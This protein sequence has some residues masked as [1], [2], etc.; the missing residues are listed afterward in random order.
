[1]AL[2][3][4]L[5]VTD[6]TR[7]MAQMGSA[8]VSTAFADSVGSIVLNHD[9][10]RNALSRELMEAAIAAFEE[11][12]RRQARAIILRANRGAKVWSAGHDVA[13]LPHPGRDPL[14]YQDPLE[15]LIRTMRTC[16]CPI[17]ALIEGSVW[18]GGCELALCCDILIGTP[19]AS[20]AITPARLGVPYNSS[21]I[22]RIM[23]VIGVRLAKE[24][25]FTGQPVDAERAFQVGILNHLLEPKRAE[26]LAYDIARHISCNSPLSI[27]VIKEQL[28]LLDDAHPLAP[29]TFERIQGLR[30]AVYDSED[31]REGI[32]AFLE[33]RPPLFRSR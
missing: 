11:H 1:M 24:M 29:E 9:A 15:R 30:R 17:I 33:K 14:S 2:A 21:G 12:L 26:D 23:N 18:G 8:L 25:F 16:P 20:F 19:S 3:L 6:E 22:L 13:E 32:N 7:Q 28:R 27:S 10:K 4:A 5:D 31:Y